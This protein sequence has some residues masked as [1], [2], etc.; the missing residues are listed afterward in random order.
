MTADSQPK[1]SGRKW[2]F[3]AARWALALLILGIL[4]YLLPPAALCSA[5]SRVPL[6]R[7]I[8][9]LLI[10]LVAVTGGVTKWHTMVNAADAQLSF[11]TSQL[12]QRAP[13]VLSTDIVWEG[14]V[15]TARLAAFLL[16]VLT[17][18][19]RGLLA[20]PTLTGKSA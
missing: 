11:A 17:N 1:K 15:I 8:A 5:L 14:A 9:V 3:L 7:F 13:Q 20:F 12:H 16:R 10:Y 2:I 4:P 6:T 18:S 19:S